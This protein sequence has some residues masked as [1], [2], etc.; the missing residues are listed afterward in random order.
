VTDLYL[1]N[2]ALTFSGEV[3]LFQMRGAAVDRTRQELRQL[4]GV[5]VFV[6]DDH[7]Y[8]YSEPAG[9]EVEPISEP[10][11]PVDNLRLW[12]VR[13]ALIDHCHGLGMEAWFG[14]GG[15]LLVI[16]ATPAV[17]EDRFRVE[18]V[19]VLRVSR[20]EY[21]DAHALLTAR[22]R[23]Q[24]R[25]AEPIS[26]PDVRARA[27]NQT[28][29]RLRGDG[30]RRGRVVRADPDRL[31]LVV[32][33]EEFEVTPEDY[34]L[35]VNASLV[36]GWRGSAALGRLRVTTG[37]LTVSGKR[38]RH[39]IADRFKL[40]GDA[41]RRLGTTVGVNGGGEVVISRVPIAIRLEDGG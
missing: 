14:F 39:G 38:N 23:T 34:T 9:V 13:G 31:V 15:E 19:L 5:H 41:V 37:E 35:A 21:V 20:E 24:W 33:E 22:H 8:A 28:A 26:D 27:I 3:S 25:S 4:T 1:N 32:G 16:G 30:P 17:V 2:Y 11:I 40:V 6:E 10:L 29:L 7:A 36:A 12:A 18:Q